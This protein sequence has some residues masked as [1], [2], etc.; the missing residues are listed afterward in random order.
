M[1][2]EIDIN[3]FDILPVKK[4]HD[5]PRNTYVRSPVTDKV[6]MFNY[7]DG[8]HS[9]CTSMLG[10]V[11]YFAAWSEFHPLIKKV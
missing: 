1:I 5:I 9:F 6:Y 8:A 4:L 2:S 3:D 11:Y 7:I 10:D